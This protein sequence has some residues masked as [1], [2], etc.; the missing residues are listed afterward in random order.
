MIKFY[1]E[2]IA[3]AFY[4]HLHGRK[5]CSEFKPEYAKKIFINKKFCVLRYQQT[6]SHR[7]DTNS[8]HGELIFIITLTWS[9]SFLRTA[10]SHKFQPIHRTSIF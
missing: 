10:G 2:H 4:H 3:S 7:F 1:Q 9:N 6:I 8:T 5:K